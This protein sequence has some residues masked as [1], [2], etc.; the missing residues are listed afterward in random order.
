LP[1]T[2]AP[3]IAPPASTWIGRALPRLEDERLVLGQ[4]QYTDDIPI[5]GE[6]HAVIVRS[7]YAHARIRKIDVSAALAAPGVLAVY[8]GADYQNDGRGPILQAPMPD[9]NLDGARAAFSVEEGAVLIEVPQQVLAVNEVFHQGEGVAMVVADTKARAVDAAEFVDVSYDELPVIVEIDQALAPDAV[10]LSP[11][12][13]GNIVIDAQR[14]DADATERAFAKADLIVEGEFRN[15]RIFSAH[16]EPRSAV[17]V[18]NAV[19]ETFTVICGGA[20][21]IRYRRVLA[22]TL[23][24]PIECMHVRTP[25]TGG[26]FGSRNN[27]HPEIVLV[28]WAAYKLGRPVRWIGTRSDGFLTD[29]QGR[30]IL[31]NAALALDATGKMLALRS[32]ATANVGA[33]TISW[34]FLNNF[35]R[36]APSI[37]AMPAADIHVR[38]V[39]SNTTPLSVYRG[40]GRPEAMFALERLLD[41][42]ALKLGISRVEIRRRN[43]IRTKPYTSATGLIY[44]S[45]DF[46]GNME[47]TLE[48]A[49]WDTFEERRAESAARGRLRGIGIANYVESPTGFPRERAVINVLPDGI[50]ELLIGTQSSGQGHETTFP[51]IVAE[52]LGVP[53]KSVVLVQGDTMRVDVGGGSHSNRSMRLGSTLIVQACNEILEKARAVAGDEPLDLFRIAETT[54]LSARADISKRMPAYPTGCAVCEVEID[55][56]TGEIETVAYTQI[57]DAGRPINPLVLHGQTHGGIAQGL[58]QAFQEAMMYDRETGQILSGSFM[59]YAMPRARHFPRLDTVLVEDRTMGNVLN[60]KGGGEAGITPSPAAAVSAVVDALRDFGVTHIE[61]PVTA[62]KVWRLISERTLQHA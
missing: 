60:I 18:Y 19:T 22:A 31:V 20:G 9:D 40:A 61:M 33:Y 43:I 26:S 25:D 58:G 15:Q 35:T 52:L 38:G 3:P 50:V 34:A 12:V 51:Q 49:Q 47:L 4:G 46:A 62:V 45:G 28:A 24:V 27:L 57:D 2:E 32:L 48:R 29:F 44:D 39:L 14:G 5:E 21:P 11:D 6:V 55:P 53:L 8:T 13:P 16:M 1:V 17:A 41:L 7:P 37:Y 54:P 56:R 23:R 36:V 30:D 59:G 10:Q 42:A